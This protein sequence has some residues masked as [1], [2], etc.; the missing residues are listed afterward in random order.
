MGHEEFR[1][2][3]LRWKRQLLQGLV[4][5]IITA[6]GGFV[7]TVA[8]QI[9]CSTYA[10]FLQHHLEAL[11]LAGMVVLMTIGV[12]LW[13]SYTLKQLQQLQNAQVILHVLNGELSREIRERQAIE[14]KL[15]QS[16]ARLAEAQQIARIGSWDFDLRTEKITWSEELFAIFGLD[17]AQSEPTYAELIQC[18]HPED[19]A[20]WQQQV[21]QAMATG[22]S[23]LIEHRVILPDG[24]IRYIEGR[25]RAEADCQGKVVR[26]FGTGMDITDRKRT[27]A[28][29]RKSE[30]RFR[31]IFEQAA[32]GICLDTLESQSL[33]MN[34]KFCDITGYSAEAIHSLHWSEITHPDDRAADWELMHRLLAGEIKHFS[35]QKR[36]FRPDHSLVWVELTASLIYNAAGE[37]ESILAMIQDISEAKQLEADRQQT[38]L[39]LRKSEERLSLALKAAKAGIWQWRITDNQAF[40]SDENFRLLGYEPG[41]CQPCYENWFNAVHPD[42]RALTEQH[43]VEALETRIDLNCEFRVVLPDG[44]IRWLADIGK[45]TYDQQNTPTGMIGIQIDITEQKQ[46]EARLQQLN[47]ELLARTRQLEI[48]NRELESFSYSVSHD[49][50]APSRH[51]HGF[52]NVLRQHLEQRTGASHHTTPAQPVL[53]AKVSHYLDVIESS[54]RKM[55][56]LIDGLL[57][58]S[59]VGRR[60]IQSRPVALSAL[61][62]E[63][64][65]SAKV[66]SDGT[67][68]IEF[69][70]GA[71]PIVEGDAVLLQQ[72]LINLID[73]AIKFSRNTDTPCIEIGS[74]P[75]QTVFVRDNGIGFAMDDAEHIFDAFQRLHGREFEGTGIGLAIV[76]RIIHRHNGNIWAESQ[77]SQGATF[78]F[79]LGQSHP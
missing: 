66:D 50:R 15:R 19:R 40:W 5:L 41:C 8:Q 60:Q 6:F 68:A 20:Q 79:Q 52:V 32:V 26:L 34:Q 61:V 39:E 30:E 24:S 58:L 27:E 62:D 14:Q 35:L 10:A 9:H 21:E 23:Y 2:S 25:G 47:R 71:L 38:E 42:D 73:N 57:T 69:R 72:V 70:V 53:D 37:P 13:R 59:R 65:E 46:A 12:I 28:A 33:Q 29:L 48:T 36:Y 17:S 54:S 75:D 55:G 63:A 67:R 43:I 7:F 44:T 49:L 76:Q 64:I 18:I 3:G 22:K 31:A 56:L 11:P 78:Y 51:I 77:P 4:L 45:I 74:L 16:E 1:V